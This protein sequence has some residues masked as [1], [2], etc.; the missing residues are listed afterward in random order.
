[1]VFKYSYNRLITLRIYILCKLI[2]I[3]TNYGSIIKV[4]DIKKDCIKNIIEIAPICDKI[5]YI[6][7]FG[8]SLE[9]S[10]K[11]QSDIDIAIISNIKRNKLFKNK[12]YDNFT[13][14][15][16]SKSLEQDYDILFFESKDD[17]YADDLICKEILQKGQILYKRNL[18][19]V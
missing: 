1:M 2:N 16:Y 15:L 8:S 5:D 18:D 19:Y 9:L 11:E 14:R 4:A 13:S 3:K 12:S 17:L 10:C 6:Y 7:I